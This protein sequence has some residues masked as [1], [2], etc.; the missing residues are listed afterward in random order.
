[1]KLN[2]LISIMINY[3]RYLGTPLS[4]FVCLLH[5][6]LKIQEK[7]YWKIDLLNICAG[8]TVFRRS[9]IFF[10][11]VVSLILNELWFSS[12]WFF[13]PSRKTNW[14]IAI[15]LHFQFHDFLFDEIIAIIL[16]YCGGNWLY[17]RVF[18]FVALELIN[19]CVILQN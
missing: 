19:Y 7:K 12:V 3:V 17:F 16:W 13:Q 2:R 1:M 4:S 5:D 8:L 18:R 11:K 9:I 14:E 10:A 15:S 6:L